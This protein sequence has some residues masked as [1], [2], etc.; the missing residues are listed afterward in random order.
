ME[1]LSN[2]ARYYQLKN[3]HFMQ[4]KLIR[5]EEETPFEYGIKGT[6]AQGK[7]TH[8]HGFLGGQ[9]NSV[10]ETVY[11][12]EVEIGDTVELTSNNLTAKV[13]YIEVEIL[14]QE[15]LQFLPYENVDKIL[16][17]TL[18]NVNVEEK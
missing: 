2:Q 16:R 7:T 12:L 9:N 11:P 3:G 13:T 1:M 4:G 8:I 10:I 6:L 14:Q 18:Q 15:Q 5:G 17:L